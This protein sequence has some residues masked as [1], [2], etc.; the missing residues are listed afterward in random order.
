[1]PQRTQPAFVIMREELRLISSDVHTDGTFSLTRLAGETQVE[2]VLDAFILPSIP[3]DLP[4]QEFE[5]HV[6]AAA[7][8]MLLFERYPVA[9]AHRSCIGF[10]ASSYADASK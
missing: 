2:R 5:Q 9:G 1:M 8:T 6:G 4:L 3:D 10:A 7:G